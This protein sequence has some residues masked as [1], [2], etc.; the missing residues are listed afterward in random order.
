MANDPNHRHTD[1]RTFGLLESNSIARGMA[2]QDAATKEAD[3]TE[4]WSRLIE[5]GRHL[6]LFAGS[7]DSVQS[8]LRRGR[9][10]LGPDLADAMFLANAHPALLPAVDGLRAVDGQADAGQADAGQAEGGSMREIASIGVIECRTVAATLLAADAAA[11]ASDVE[12]CRVA[13]DDRL[14]GKGVVAFTG[15]I[16]DVESALS[17]GARVAEGHDALIRTESID[18]PSEGLLKAFRR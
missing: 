14:G 5:P 4:I 18:A 9:A 17:A 15:L 7:V 1:N 2:A 3:V 16:A 6:F 10:R 8:A 11:K 13:I 12:L